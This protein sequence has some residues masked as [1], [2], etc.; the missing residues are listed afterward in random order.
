MTD[1]DCEG[2]TLAEMAGAATDEHTSA[3]MVES[4]LRRLVAL[5]LVI[6][7]PHHP[8]RYLFPAGLMRTLDGTTLPREP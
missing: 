5:G 1:S 4:A 7:C 3:E 2:A 8:G 6:E